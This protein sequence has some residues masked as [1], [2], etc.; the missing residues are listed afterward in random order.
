M[1]N[2]QPLTSPTISY[3][4]L[5]YCFINIIV[6]YNCNEPLSW[7]GSFLASTGMLPRPLPNDD[8]PMSI[9]GLM[10]ASVSFVRLLP[11]LPPLFPNSRFVGNI[12][13]L[14][15]TEQEYNIYSQLQ[16]RPPLSLANN[17]LSLHR[18]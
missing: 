9:C 10:S 12:L 5:F 1:A 13:A 18:C 3:C 17:R 11:A 2:T 8:T 6:V 7:A 14:K 15:A 16:Q 4:I